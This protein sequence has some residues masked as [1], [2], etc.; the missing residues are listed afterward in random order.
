MPSVIQFRTQDL[1]SSDFSVVLI[2]TLRQFMEELENGALV[3]V[4]LNKSKVRILPI[5]KS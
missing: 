2:N 3:T 5:Y 4:E 1:L